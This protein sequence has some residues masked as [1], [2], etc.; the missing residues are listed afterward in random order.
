M[1]HFRTSHHSGY[2]YVTAIAVCELGHVPDLVD[3]FSGVLRAL[4]LVVFDLLRPGLD[5]FTAHPSVVEDYFRMVRA[6]WRTVRAR[7]WCLLERA[8]L[9]RSCKTRCGSAHLRCSSWTRWRR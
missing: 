5:A 8:W 4:S 9:L 7:C 3:P 2:L 1:N 6:R